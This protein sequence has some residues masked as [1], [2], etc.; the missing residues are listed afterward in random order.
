L[1]T[2]EIANGILQNTLKQQRQLLAWPVTVTIGQFEHRILND[3]QRSV[4]VAD[5]KN[6][7]F[8]CTALHLEE[9]FTQFVFGSQGAV[10]PC[11]ACAGCV[12]A[13]VFVF[14]GCRLVRRSSILVHI[15][16]GNALKRPDGVDISR[17]IASIS[18]NTSH[19]SDF[20]A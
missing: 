14:A 3:V 17:Q 5:G 4:V 19:A 10:S 1:P 18:W 16:L 11:L 7:L 6:S 13:K 8:E 12:P 15:V 2:V 9:E 20:M